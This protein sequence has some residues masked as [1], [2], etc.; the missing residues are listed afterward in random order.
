MPRMSMESAMVPLHYSSLERSGRLRFEVEGGS[1]YIPLPSSWDDYLARLASS[2]RRLV[3]TSLRDFE[4]WSAGRHCLKVAK[5]YTELEVG[6]RV[7]RELHEL[8]WRDDGKS[9]AFA[10]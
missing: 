5:S 1:P 6:R 4:E 9:G 10:S 7:L 8:R 2:R 3:R